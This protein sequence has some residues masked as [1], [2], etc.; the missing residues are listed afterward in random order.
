MSNVVSVKKK[1]PRQSKFERLWQRAT[2]LKADN[3]ALK[4]SLDQLILRVQQEVIPYEKALAESQKPLG[5]KL[6]T[7]GQR[8]TMTNWERETLHEWVGEVFEDLRD[9]NL[10]DEDWLNH[11]AR[12]DAFRMGIELEEGEAPYEAL[13][14]KMQQFEEEARARQEEE[15]RAYQE[16]EQEAREAYFRDGTKKIEMKLDRVLGPRP[17][18]TQSQTDDLWKDELDEAISQE[19]VA[20]DARR[21]ALRAQMLEE[22]NED[23]A[24]IFDDQ[25]DDDDDFDNLDDIDDLDAFL[26]EQAEKIFN[27]FKREG[28]NEVAENPAGKDN[29]LTTDT[30]QR[31]FRATAAKL[32]P[33]REPDPALRDKKQQ[34]MASLLKARKRGD[35]I[36]IIDLYKTWVGDQNSLSQTDEKAL[37]SALE[38]WV[39]TLEAEKHEI[40]AESPMHFH[41]YNEYHHRSKRKVDQSLKKRIDA[42]ERAVVAN[43]RLGGSITSLKSLKPWLEQRFE[44][45]RWGFN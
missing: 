8:K 44:Q 5:I 21:E 25:D 16:Q 36:T 42:L 19:Q 23:I 31:L 20:Y 37:H 28:D 35:I 38:Q 2:R 6:L 3:D 27:S 34:L 22:L 26:N 12:Y 9:F 4:S 45:T 40:I 10:I 30:F 13:S 18:T 14:K 33:D 15:A 43:Q 11:M 1:K 41:V 17:E 29:P 32:H 7:L 39:S 24:L